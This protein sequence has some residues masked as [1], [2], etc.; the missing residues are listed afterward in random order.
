ML[1][2]HIIFFLFIFCFMFTI[3][4]EK[5]LKERYYDL[6]TDS[7]K[8]DF[9]F[10]EIISKQIKDF[11]KLEKKIKELEADKDLLKKHKNQQ[12]VKLLQEDTLSKSKKIQEL[13]SKIN[14]IDI[15]IKKLNDTIEYNDSKIF[16]LEEQIRIYNNNSEQEVLEVENFISYIIEQKSGFI[17]EEFL[18]M[19]LNKLIRLKSNSDLIIDLEN[20]IKINKL[21]VSSKSFL[22]QPFNESKS[23]AIIDEL[24]NIEI[25][26]KF[27]GF[28]EEQ[29]DIID[30]LDNYKEKCI[31]LS[32]LF[33]DLNQS[34]NVNSTNEDIIGFFE[35]EISQFSNYPYLL[36][37]INQKIN[38]PKKSLS[39][40]CN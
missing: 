8:I 33:K 13:E 31:Y 4:Q 22:N 38:N 24:E 9:F 32:E 23:S 34:L 19:H 11:Q 12:T 25:N 29:W 18:I 35:S 37:L 3:A 28:N 15:Q 27:K 21:F 1:K 39:F 36:D 14:D 16:Q 6:E 7:E 26:S 30:L 20:Y 10:D 5:T 2:K 40:F 17:K